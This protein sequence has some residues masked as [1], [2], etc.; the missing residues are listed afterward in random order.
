MGT[1]NSLRVLLLTGKEDYELEKVLVASAQV[2]QTRHCFHIK[3]AYDACRDY[4]PD[5]VLVK[6]QTQKG[7]RRIATDLHIKVLV[8]DDEAPPPLYCSTGSVADF[9]RRK[10]S[11]L[12]LIY[13]A[14]NPN[15]FFSQTCPRNIAVSSPPHECLAFLKERGANVYVIEDRTPWRVRD[16]LNRSKISLNFGVDHFKITTCGAMM[17]DAG[18]EAG[19][20]YDSQSEMA[21]F[22]DQEELLERLLFFWKHH[23]QREETAQRGKS[24]SEIWSV[25]N[26]W[27][28][29]FERMGFPVPDF[30]EKAKSYRLHRR[31]IEGMR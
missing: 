10:R 27:G 24:K 19:N 2:S 23:E 14:V 20:F 7:L 16:I 12:L 9:R 28:H 25:W 3:E 5:L 29:A 6:G 15:D 22:H 4:V 31:L 13:D 26:C 1:G 17:L 11:N 8:L 30:L 18:T 21:V